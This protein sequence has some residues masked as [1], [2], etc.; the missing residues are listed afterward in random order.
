MTV[1]STPRRVESAQCHKSNTNKDSVKGLDAFPYLQ[2]IEYIVD[3]ESQPPLT[4]LLQTQ[5]YS[6]VGV[7][8]RDYI[9]E[10]WERNTLS[11]LETHLQN[12]P[13]YPF[14]T[15]EHYKYIQC[16]IKTKGMKTYYDNVL[17][18]ENTTQFFPR[19]KNGD[20]AQKLWLPWQMIRLCGRG[21]YILLRI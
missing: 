6:T 7:Q 1:H 17:Q 18:E 5:P 16:G 12:N 13:Y 2:H 19:F 20:G 8:L 14:A 15:R 9:P 10:P 11:C 3:S 4:P 21:N